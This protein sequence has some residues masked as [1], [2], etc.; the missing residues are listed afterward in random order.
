MKNYIVYHKP[1]G[2][3]TA[4]SDPRQKTVMD[5]F[6]MAYRKLFPVGRLDKETEGLLLFTDDG[7]LA[8]RLLHPA[9]HVEKTY[10]FYSYGRLSKE[11]MRALETGVPLGKGGALSAPA[12]L[13]ILRECPL[14]SIKDAL[15]EYEKKRYRRHEADPV[16]VGTLTVTEGKKHQIRKMLLSVGGRVIYLRRIAFGPLALG[17]LPRGAL[18]ELTEQEKQALCALNEETSIK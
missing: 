5:S 6:P 10:L 8:A 1:R 2:E 18:R 17:S 12:R 9:H 14:S 4:R 7:A 15:S 11:N 3:L 16:T 13:Y